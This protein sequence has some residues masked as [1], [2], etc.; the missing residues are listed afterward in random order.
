MVRQGNVWQGN[1]EIILTNAVPY[2]VA[3][4][5]SAL[6]ILFR[7]AR[8]GYGA[9]R[10]LRPTL[11]PMR[12]GAQDL[13]AE[14]FVGG[15]DAAVGFQFVQGGHGHAEI[16]G[17]KWAAADDAIFPAVRVGDLFDFLGGTRI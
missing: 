6:A 7:A 11:L 15:E 3:V 2:S 4:H 5:S 14:T 13:Q 10:Q 16:D 9:E 1:G 12:H 8:N 17:G